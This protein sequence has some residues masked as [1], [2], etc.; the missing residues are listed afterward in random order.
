MGNHQS[1]CLQSPP[2]ISTEKVDGLVVPT[3]LEDKFISNFDIL[4]F[5]QAN[6]D[7]V[8][9][10]FIRQHFGELSF[11]VDKYLPNDSVDDAFVRNTVIDGVRY[12][13]SVDPLCKPNQIND[14]YLK[15]FLRDILVS[16]NLN[17]FIVCR[18]AELCLHWKEN[19][20]LSDD[21]QLS[22]FSESMEELDSFLL[23]KGL[24][25]LSKSQMLRQHVMAM[26]SISRVRI[27]NKTMAVDSESSLS[28]L[29]ELLKQ[30]GQSFDNRVDRSR[31][32][33]LRE[34]GV[35]VDKISRSAEFQ[36]WIRDRCELQS[37]ALKEVIDKRFGYQGLK[38]SCG[39][40]KPVSDVFE[41]IW[42][43]LGR[44]W[45]PQTLEAV[46]KDFLELKLER[47]LLNLEGKALE[48][49][50][51]E[52]WEIFYSKDRLTTSALVV[53]IKK[54]VRKDGRSEEL[55]IQVNT[56][57]VLME[58][59]KRLS[60]VKK[61]NFALAQMNGKFNSTSGRKLKTNSNSAVITGDV[62]ENE[63]LNATVHSHI[64]S[65]NESKG[66]L[67][68]NDD[69]DD[70]DGSALLVSS[71]RISSLLNP[72]F[73]KVERA[74]T[75]YKEILNISASKYEENVITPLLSSQDVDDVLD[76]AFNSIQKN[77]N[78]TEK[79]INQRVITTVYN[80][81]NSI[82]SCIDVTSSSS[83]SLNQV[84]SRMRT[85]A[86]TMLDLEDKLLVND[87]VFCSGRHPP[88]SKNNNSTT[89][90]NGF[91]NSSRQ[92]Q[93]ISSSA[94][95]SSRRRV[96][97][98]TVFE[99]SAAGERTEDETGAI[100]H[101]LMPPL[102]GFRQN[103]KLDM[104]LADM[105][106]SSS[107]FS[108]SLVSKQ[109][110]TISVLPL[111]GNSLLSPTVD[112]H[113]QAQKR[114]PHVVS[115]TTNVSKNNQDSERRTNLKT[116]PVSANI[117]EGIYSASLIG[118]DDQNDINNNNIDAL[119]GIVGINE[120]EEYL[121]QDDDIF[122]GRNNEIKIEDVYILVETFL[123]SYSSLSHVN[124]F[125]E[126]GN[127]IA[128]PLQTSK[129]QVSSVM[130][131]SR[132]VSFNPNA[133]LNSMLP[134]L[135]QNGNFSGVDAELKREI[136]PL[137]LISLHYLRVA[138]SLLNSRFSPSEPNT[139][140]QLNPP[141][142]AA[143]SK[144]LSNSYSGLKS[145]LIVDEQRLK[146][147]Q[148]LIQLHT[149][150]LQ[151]EKN[152]MY[153]PATYR[154]ECLTFAQKS[155]SMRQTNLEKRVP[156][157]EQLRKS[158]SIA[159]RLMEEIVWALNVG[160]YSNCAQFFQHVT[161]QEIDGWSAGDIFWNSIAPS[162]PPQVQAYVAN[163]FD[164]AGTLPN[165]PNA[166]FN[167]TSNSVPV[168]FPK[169]EIRLNRRGSEAVIN[170]AFAVQ[171]PPPVVPSELNNDQS[172]TPDQGNVYQLISPVVNNGVYSNTSVHT[173]VSP[174][175]SALPYKVLG[176]HSAVANAS[177]SN[178]AFKAA[179]RSASPESTN[180]V[181]RSPPN[182][183]TSRQNNALEAAAR[184]EMSGHQ[185]VSV[186]SS[187]QLGG[188]GRGY[189]DVIS[190][191]QQLDI[192]SENKVCW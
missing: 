49:W 178:I 94:C 162:L 91:A 140:V 121:M 96:R 53:R 114:S 95:N 65:N 132:S 175:R 31:T 3:A 155:V 192:P 191:E 120:Q 10:S 84:N 16:P 106:S 30:H 165:R 39:F 1:G 37:V 19:C 4:T 168:N 113:H 133:T 63:E 166:N 118:D 157:L 79:K 54:M 151:Q 66:N 9:S 107:P 78:S 20:E 169:S 147:L 22:I 70:V 100:L 177:L 101:N 104:P 34:A 126:G 97:G 117:D 50:E 55:I 171:R 75:L 42:H 144:N 186:L 40:A 154:R 77:N 127:A 71:K 82:L 76:N 188:R 90:G 172:K 163:K 60:F 68:S 146:D 47:E 141:Q 189:P 61:E 58:L 115:Q 23:H 180:R 131:P 74:E 108:P 7:K 72:L 139:S 27:P 170:V 52:L 57:K 111:S 8:S 64:K 69:D 6:S 67:F 142:E 92:L 73:E 128:A 183:G 137:E 112:F 62:I 5:L 12:F 28:M 173:T 102:S 179:S 150:Q 105:K 89:A 45:L 48:D 164:F 156:A 29:V 129:L 143:Q 24:S 26:N 160:I 81:L 15:E 134:S 136:I 93:V 59:M 33:A 14:K 122:S 21:I 51:K 149:P 25:K 176:Q 125:S 83:S 87:I 32:I 130:A 159:I 98:G 161:I 123:Y 41:S 43:E 46:T 116:P 99:T 138:F 36:A 13:F 119:L 109:F 17:P 184:I 152:S 167:S 85:S 124:N 18:V 190:A 11:N 2:S 35:A 44:T 174:S 181:G 80:C 185:Q 110:T 187:N 148:T 56:L 153:C 158:I 182:N 103:P 135:R 145:N 86:F 38:N 88:H